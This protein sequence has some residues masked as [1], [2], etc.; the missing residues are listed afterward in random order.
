MAEAYD[1]AIRRRLGIVNDMGSSANQAAANWNQIRR[2]VTPPGQPVR[3]PEY[4]GG[5]AVRMPVYNG[6]G[7]HSYK[8]PRGNQQ[9]LINF[10][11]FLQ[12]QGFRVS[13]NSFFDGGRRTTS[14]HSR[15]S[16]H[17]SDRAIDVNFAP[18]TSRREQQAIDRIVGLAQLYGLRPIW[19][20][21]NHFNHAHFDF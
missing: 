10:G 15:G 14:G 20:Q 13:E 19:R 2:G 5:Q 4:G 1:A 16:R 9:A 17:Y 12:S 21:P 3:R 7:G 6:Q 11:K 8:G 18:G